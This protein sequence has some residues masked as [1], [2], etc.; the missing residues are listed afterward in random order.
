M[1][2]KY[3]G[4]IFLL[5]LLSGCT[6][7][8]LKQVASLNDDEEMPVVVMTNAE[9]EFTDS[10]ILKAVIA[11]GKVETFNYYNDKNKLEDQKL[12]MT[13]GVNAKFYNKL[14][15]INSVMTSEQAIRKEKARMT[16]IEGNAIVVNVKGDSLSSEFLL[17][18]ENANTISSDRKVRVKTQDE[19]IFAEGFKSDIGFS[20]YTFEKVTGTISL[21]SSK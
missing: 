11:A 16:E 14:G 18:D 5:L 9:I 4:F 15:E 19:I 2:L 6:E 3:S 7:N 10:A 17:W 1:R 20:E 8:D 13:E 12:V 21:K